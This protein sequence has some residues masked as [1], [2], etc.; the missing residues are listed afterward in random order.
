VNLSGDST[1]VPTTSQGE[2]D[3]N[4]YVLT[5]VV[6]M[7]GFVVVLVLLVVLFSRRKEATTMAQLV[8]MEE[9]VPL[10]AASSGGLLARAQNKK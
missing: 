4:T 9:E 10:E 5:G 7:F 2:S 3:G 1:P 6:L 8:E